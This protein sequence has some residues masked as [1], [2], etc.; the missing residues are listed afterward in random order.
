MN[1]WHPQSMSRIQHSLTSL[2]VLWPSPPGQLC[3]AAHWRQAQLVFDALRRHCHFW[4]FLITLTAGSRSSV[5]WLCPL[6]P[7]PVPR[8][9]PTCPRTCLLSCWSVWF[10]WTDLYGQSS[11]CVGV[12]S[13]TSACISEGSVWAAGVKSPE[14]S[15]WSQVSEETDKEWWIRHLDSC[16]WR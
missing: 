8:S 12:G 15:C 4:A 14:H 2:L 9:S 3:P 7:C 10:V 11:V 1:K 5:S 16:Q 13:W 6:C